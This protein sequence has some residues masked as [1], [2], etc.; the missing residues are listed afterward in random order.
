MS[1]D[2]TPHLFWITSRAAGSAA[3]VVASL[4]VC[5]GLLMGT[6]LLKRFGTSD[7]RVAH[8]TL[9]L[10]T[11]GA[12]AVN[13]VSLIGDS[14][15]PP[16]QIDVS[17]PFVGPYKTGWTSAG[18]ISGWTLAALGLSYYARG[19]IGPDRWRRLHRFTALAWLLGLVHS[20]GE[21]TDAGETWFLAM[22]GIVVL[23]A[24]ALLVWRVSQSH[25]GGLVL[26]VHDGH[27]RARSTRNWFQ[28]A[29]QQAS[30][31]HACR[32]SRTATAAMT[33]AVS[34]SAHHQPATT[35]APSPTRSAPRDR[36]RP[37]SG[38]LH[39]SQIAPGPRGAAARWL[40]GGLGLG[41][42]HCQDTLDDAPLR[43]FES[44]HG[45]PLGLE[46]VQRLAS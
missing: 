21:G 34:G 44:L 39:S 45:E 35:F 43:A 2:P 41:W 20:L 7:L 32:P 27:T 31:R 19:R 15:M 22:I 23:P 1:T 12:I 18:V 17:V 9:S 30:P 24:L 14:Y 4:G 36:H 10:A 37:C 42:L 26:Q 11:I 13:G 5:L 3:L 33:R 8:E 38:G 29:A 46:M 16:T 25:T 6:R 40:H 28:Q